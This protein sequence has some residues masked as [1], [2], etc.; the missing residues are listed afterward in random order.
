MHLHQEHP[1]P[2]AIVEKHILLYEKLVEQRDAN[3]IVFDKQHWFFF[4]ILT[5]PSYMEQIVKRWEAHEPR[6]D[7]WHP[8]LWRALDGFIHEPQINNPSPL[9]TP[10]TG[11]PPGSTSIDSGSGPGGLIGDLTHG[12]TDPGTPG[13]GTPGAGTSGGGT[14]KPGGSPPQAVPEP[15]GIVLMFTGMI[16][17]G[18]GV[19]RRIVWDHARRTAQAQRR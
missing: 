11:E 2:G 8:Y 9:L 17:A 19:A 3:P 15:P 4:G 16:L 18:L 7:H 14:N 13:V 5:D 6:F 10:G 1:E 12:S